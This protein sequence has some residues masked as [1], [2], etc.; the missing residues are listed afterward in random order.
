MSER[1]LALEV[2]VDPDTFNK[3]VN[4]KD[5]EPNVPTGVLFA[6]SK[7]LGVPATELVTPEDAEKMREAPPI[8]GEQ[9][10]GEKSKEVVTKASVVIDKLDIALV[11]IQH[12]V[13]VLRK[14]VT[15]LD[16]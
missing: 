16:E 8:F 6:I 9:R 1:E 15:E 7:I 13:A 4:K 10:A 12:D 3:W 14:L 2:G 5:R 11:S